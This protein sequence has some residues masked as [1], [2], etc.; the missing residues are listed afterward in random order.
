MGAFV[1]TLEFVADPMWY[2]NSGATNHSTPDIKNLNHQTEY[3]GNESLSVGNG[4]LLTIEDVGYSV[5]PLKI[6]PKT[7]LHLHNIL[8]VPDLTKSLLSISKLCKDNHVFT[9]FHS[10]RCFVKDKVTKRVLLKGKVKD[11]LY[12]MELSYPMSSTSPKINGNHNQVFKS[13]YIHYC[14][15]SFMFC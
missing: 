2:A 6:N 11:G 10:D 1:A 13:I 5:V 8:H 14:L 9:E 4:D 3:K 7:H 12:H 15:E